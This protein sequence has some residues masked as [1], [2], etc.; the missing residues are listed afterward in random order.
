MSGTVENM[1][2]LARESD[3]AT[4]AMLA[5]N[6]T[7]PHEVLAYLSK[8]HEPRV[9]AS[10]VNNMRAPFSV[11]RTLTEDEN[12]EVRESL[13]K[14]VAEIMPSLTSSSHDRL[15]Q[16]LHPILLKLAEDT[17]AQ[18]RFIIADAAKNLSTVPRD[19]VL[20]LAMDT[21]I[22]V[23]EPI[24]RL[25][26]L[27]TEEDLLMMV[28]SPPSNGTLQ[29]VARRIGIGEA[30]TDALITQGDRA[31]IGLMLENTSAKIRAASMEDVLNRAR[32]NPEWF[33]S[34]M[35]RPTLTPDTAIRMAGVVADTLLRPLM[36][37]PD[38]DPALL[39]RIRQCVADRLGLPQPNLPA[40]VSSRQVDPVTKGF[41]AKSMVWRTDNGGPRF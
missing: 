4:R 27:L 17:V 6:A 40:G 37:R 35:A 10:V 23:A 29:A 22:R 16:A 8:D 30:V 11:L 7:T 41:P 18:I 12:A 1:L 3:T 32:F 2:R 36:Q 38:V 24:I 15:A 5:R 34:L 28:A 33:P 13:A 21:E 25:S 14:R 19:A 26:P 39:F 31:A 9:R 20:R